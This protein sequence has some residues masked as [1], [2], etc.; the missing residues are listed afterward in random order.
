MDAKEFKCVGV[1]GSSFSLKKLLM[2]KLHDFLKNDARSD[3]LTRYELA[4]C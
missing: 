2:Q 3:G 4:P 1:A